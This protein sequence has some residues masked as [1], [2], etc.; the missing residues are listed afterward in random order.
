M[1][2]VGIA[3]F[4]GSGVW[5]KVAIGVNVGANE[6]TAFGKTTSVGVGTM[7]TLTEDNAG[8]SLAC[9]VPILGSTGA[10]RTG[11]QIL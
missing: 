5:V 2:V 3:V 1:T 9:T 10:T 8:L 6:G 7:I 11:V 4:D